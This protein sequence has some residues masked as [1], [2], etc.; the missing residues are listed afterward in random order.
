ME[1][2]DWYAWVGLPV[3]VFF[4]RVADVT[5]GTMRIIFT[6]RG[7]RNVAPFLGFVEVLIWIVI[8]SQVI[9]NVHSVTSYLGYAAGFATGTYVGMLIEDRMAIGMRVLRIILTEGAEDLAGALR[10][11][12]FGVT[13]VNGE[14]A[15]GPVK[16]LFTVVP[17]RSMAIVSGIIRQMCPDAFYSVEEVRS[18]K[19]GIF[20]ASEA[21]GG[22]L[23][24]LK[25]K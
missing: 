5:L 24:S 15:H 8:V 20:P 21:E 11:A 18:A 12:G 14:G 2:F 13:T 17:R 23:A 22:I 6:S 1:T 16:M 4:S 9:R 7:K 10:A 19:M 25:R 3:L